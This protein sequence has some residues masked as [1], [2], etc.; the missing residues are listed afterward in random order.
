MNNSPA[1]LVL[2]RATLLRF[3]NA[4]AD[5]GIKNT[6]SIKSVSKRLLKRRKQRC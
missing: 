1:Q 3:I 6:N 2:D 5:F 4:Y